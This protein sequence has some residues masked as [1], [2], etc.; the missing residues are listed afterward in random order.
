[1]LKI[2]DNKGNMHHTVYFVTEHLLGGDY[3]YMIKKGI[4]VEC[5]RIPYY[6]ITKIYV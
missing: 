1:M 5:G 3:G 6:T 2:F 4:R